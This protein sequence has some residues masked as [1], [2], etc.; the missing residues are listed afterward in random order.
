[1][2]GGCAGLLGPDDQEQIAHAYGP[3]VV[4]LLAA[5]RRFDPDGA[6]SAIPLP[7]R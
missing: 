3:N 6:F 1:L 5:K 7:R 4:R 2:P